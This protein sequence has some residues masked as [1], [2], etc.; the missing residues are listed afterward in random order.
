MGLGT[1][2]DQ[3]GPVGTSWD[4]L[5][6]RCDSL[7]DADR[8]DLRSA[9]VRQTRLWSTPGNCRHIRTGAT[10]I[11]GLPMTL[12]RCGKKSGVAGKLR[13]FGGHRSGQQRAT[14]SK[15]F[16]ALSHTIKKINR[17]GRRLG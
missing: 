9:G 13:I 6:P 1:S 10:S 14:G 2:W 5:G 7:C 11:P 16:W 8:R 17:L 15:P 12:R 3:L 4:Q